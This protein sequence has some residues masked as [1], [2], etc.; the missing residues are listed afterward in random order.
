MN[1][2]M[3]N[4]V[5]GKVFDIQRYSIHDGSGIRTIVFLKGCPLKCRWC[6]NPESQQRGEE[7]L[8][9]T[10]KCVMCDAC[11]ESCKKGALHFQRGHAMVNPEKCDLCGECLEKCRQHGIRI[12]G[13]DY[14]AQALLEEVLKD[15]MFFFASGGGV[16]IS[17]GEPFA[18]YDFLMEFL[19]R[20]QMRGL[21]TAIET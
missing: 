5:M 20:C 16:T 15:E 4:T 13:R 1:D 12:S 7:L 9:A 14:D 18:Q 19:E 21:H 17:G 3:G 2:C 10:T 6:A 11:I 8:F